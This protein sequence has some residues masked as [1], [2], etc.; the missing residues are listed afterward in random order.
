MFLVIEEVLDYFLQ[1]HFLDGEFIRV[2][3]EVCSDEMLELDVEDEFEE[4]VDEVA[5][6]DEKLT[7]LF[8][9]TLV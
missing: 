6:F 5:L 2:V 8:I 3:G 7:L 4:G 1:K 9:E